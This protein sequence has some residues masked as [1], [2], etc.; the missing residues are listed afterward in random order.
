MSYDK[1]TSETVTVETGQFKR[2]T[3]R[4][5]KKRRIETVRFQKNPKKV[6]LAQINDL[7]LYCFPYENSDFVFLGKFPNFTMALNKYECRALIVFYNKARWYLS[8]GWQN[9]AHW[10]KQAQKDSASCEKAFNMGLK[11]LKDNQT[12]ARH[13]YYNIGRGE[14]KH[15]T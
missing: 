8:N 14:S 11:Q 15:E 4:K 9:K 12:E 3:I 2:T 7:Q 5:G 13:T 6:V 1:I 10:T